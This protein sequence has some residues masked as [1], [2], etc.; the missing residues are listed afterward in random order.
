MCF[1]QPS[2]CPP[3]QE[4]PHASH[5]ERKGKRR[6]G[7]RGDWLITDS[8]RRHPELYQGL[9][10]AAGTKK[11]PFSETL[12]SRTEG[13]GGEVTHP[14]GTRCQCDIIYHI[15]EPQP[16]TFTTPSREPPQLKMRDWLH[17]PTRPQDHSSWT[18]R[19]FRRS[20]MCPG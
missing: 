1:P 11:P 12:L 18:P 16:P 19:D 8:T 10:W 4:P 3:P 20:P 7:D 15:S 2:S 9:E 6:T 13:T 14:S 17:V 5:E